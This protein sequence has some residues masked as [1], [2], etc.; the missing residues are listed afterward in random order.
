MCLHVSA[1]G[2]QL[3]RH[4]ACECLLQSRSQDLGS[5]WLGY[6]GPLS[7]ILMEHTVL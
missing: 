4:R 2:T 6:V 7:H 3:A 5:E 1:E